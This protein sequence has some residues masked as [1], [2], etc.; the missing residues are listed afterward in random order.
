MWLDPARRL[1]R[2]LFAGDVASPAEDVGLGRRAG[3]RRGGL[4]VAIRSMRRSAD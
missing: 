4:T 2:P 1:P 3:H